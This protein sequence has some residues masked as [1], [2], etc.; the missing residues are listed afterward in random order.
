[1]PYLTKV[2]KAN[3]VPIQQRREKIKYGLGIHN[4]KAL[5]LPRRRIEGE[6]LADIIGFVSRNADTIK[7]IGSTVG[8]V[9]NSIGSVAGT[10]IDVVKKIRELNRQ[11]IQNTALEKVLAAKK[12][13]PKQGNG[14]YLID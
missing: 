4:G 1:M 5:Y 14:F 9:A 13:E 12:E 2:E 7:N 8:S 6:S 11:G 3:L 10:T